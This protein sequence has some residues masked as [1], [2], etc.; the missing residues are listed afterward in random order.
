MGAGEVAVSWWRWAE[1]AVGW[2][3][4]RDVR[5]GLLLGV[6]VVGLQEGAG[7]GEVAWDAEEERSTLAGGIGRWW[8]G[9]G[10][11]AARWFG[12]T[13]CGFGMPGDLVE[14]C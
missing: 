11:V 6:G 8:V 10:H 1:G 4:V 9:V 12:G 2:E 5:D 13:G 14:Y 7:G 3:C